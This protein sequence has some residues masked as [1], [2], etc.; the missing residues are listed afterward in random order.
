MHDMAMH[1]HIVHAYVRMLVCLLPNEVAEGSGAD[2][3]APLADAQVSSS[4]K[5]VD[6]TDESTVH[7][8][9]PAPSYTD[10]RWSGVGDADMQ[11]QSTKPYFQTTYFKGT[12]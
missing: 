10:S 6:L 8:H 9:G 2:V 12:V 11:T 5:P 1:R 7:T 4:G 3:V